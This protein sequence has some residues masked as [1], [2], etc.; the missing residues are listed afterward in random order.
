M[1]K[2]S[3]ISLATIILATVLTAIAHAQ[4]TS[5]PRVIANVPFAFTV[6]KTTLPAG[7]YTISVLNP[8]SD[9][10]VL[11]V[12]N[13]ESRASAIILTNSVNTRISDNAKLVFERYDDRYFFAEAQMAGDST[14]L[15]AIRSK[16]G[17]HAVA[18]NTKK[19]LVVITIG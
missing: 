19:T 5:P 13:M 12:R 16:S 8:S 1:K 18:T 3:H 2:L 17:K 4:T 6:G 10:K 14:S 15:A 11:Q 7:R 9:R